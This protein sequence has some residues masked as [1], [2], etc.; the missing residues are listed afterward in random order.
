M[1]SRHIELPYAC[2]NIIEIASVAD[3]SGVV[4]DVMS[5]LLAQ[6]SRTCRGPTAGSQ[7]LTTAPQVLQR[8]CQLSNHFRKTSF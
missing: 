4:A 1:T 2:G 5:A 7:L 3:T 8:K 6:I